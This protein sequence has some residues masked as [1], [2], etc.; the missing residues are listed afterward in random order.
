MTIDT[1]PL[2]KALLWAGLEDYCA[3][4]QAVWEIGAL[5]PALSEEARLDQTRLLVQTLFDQGAIELV[6]VQWATIEPTD[7]AMAHQ[8]L[9]QP[10]A[11][12]PQGE[13]DREL[14]FITTEA[15]EQR[16]TALA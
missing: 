15:G 11:W 7:P 13:Y 12:A 10:D 5:V 14:C 2:V 3:L 1:A 9:A 16:Y 4:W 6:S 8:L